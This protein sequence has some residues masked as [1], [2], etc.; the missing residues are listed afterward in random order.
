[1][2]LTRTGKQRDELLKA[3]TEDDAIVIERLLLTQPK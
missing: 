3:A 2:C 1:M